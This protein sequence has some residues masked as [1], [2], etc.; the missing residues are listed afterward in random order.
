MHYCFKV[1]CIAIL[2]IMPSLGISGCSGGGSSS[3]ASHSNPFYGSYS[4]GFMQKCVD[5][6]YFVVTSY[7]TMTMDVDAVGLIQSNFK[8]TSFNTQYTMT[9][10]VD[11]L[12]ELHMNVRS[13]GNL[14]GLTGSLVLSN[15]ALT[16][17]YSGTVESDTCTYTITTH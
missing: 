6:Q 7:G 2:F 11:H 9:G 14:Y 17:N 3:S 15:G 13:S 12:G 1:I 4:G 16:G 10:V 8:N 5:H